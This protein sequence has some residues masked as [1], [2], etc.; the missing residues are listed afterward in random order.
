MK[1]S[2]HEEKKAR[3]AK[4]YAKSVEVLAF[5]QFCKSTTLENPEILPLLTPPL[6]AAAQLQNIC[7]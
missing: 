6:D 4:E 7:R 2:Q 1:S 3:A 5:K